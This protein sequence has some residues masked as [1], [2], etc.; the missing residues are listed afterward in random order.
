MLDS[1]TVIQSATADDAALVRLLLHAC[2]L[3]LSGLEVAF[4]A[5]YC[6]AREEGA[7]VGVAGM[8]RHGRVG[9]LRSVAVAHPHR[10]RDLARRL[11]E[12]RMAYARQLE[13]QAVY[14]LTTTAA[15]YFRRLGFC[16][17][18]RGEVPAELRRS[19]EF[20]SVCPASATCLAMIV[21]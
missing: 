10:G 20:A 4:P 16:D 11:V 14:L 19:S 8:E 5:G 17:T 13:L 2:Q 18:A 15:D 21:R 9:L 3:P 12:D 7:I 6:V 1:R